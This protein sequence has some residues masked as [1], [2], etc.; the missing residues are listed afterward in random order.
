[1][2]LNNMDKTVDPCEDFYKFTCGGFEDRVVIQ[3]DRSSR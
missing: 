2:I 1:M 3:D